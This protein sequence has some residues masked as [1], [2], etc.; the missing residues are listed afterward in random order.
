[1][2][3][4]SSKFQA[5]CSL[6]FMQQSNWLDLSWRTDSRIGY[7]CNGNNSHAISSF[8][9]A[10]N[11]FLMCSAR[12]F[13]RTSPPSRIAKQL[14]PQKKY[15][16]DWLSCHCYPY[17]YPPALHFKAKKRF[18]TGEIPQPANKSGNYLPPVPSYS[19]SAAA[20]LAYEFLFIF[21][22]RWPPTN[23]CSRIY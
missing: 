14:S 9:L 11:H 7:H 18:S 22:L 6:V 23:F 2:F 17:P 5:V 16:T 13:T 21:F 12:F 15:Q 10:N 3:S 19:S 20:D 4:V 8:L 1:M